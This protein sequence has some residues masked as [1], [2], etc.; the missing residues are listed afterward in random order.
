MGLLA[1]TASAAPQRPSPDELRSTVREILRSGYR[2][3]VP[4]TERINRWIQWLLHRIGE[5]LSAVS[6]GGGILAGLPQWANWVI[7][8]VGLA[9]ITG[10]LLHIALTMR[11]VLLGDEGRSRRRPTGATEAR[12]PTEVLALAEQ[13]VHEGEYDRAVRL[14]YLATILRL[15]RLG[16]LSHDPSRTNWE[17][18]HALSAEDSALHT[19]MFDLTGVVDACIYGGTTATARTWET[20][21]G[22]ADVLWHAE[23]AAA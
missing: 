16:L 10:I 22:S 7:F 1:A 15:D 2:L 21:R 3:Q 20:A 12:D 13:A 19:A 11:S 9:A 6:Q 14:L 18:L 23:A 17:N 8:G 4:P 5:G